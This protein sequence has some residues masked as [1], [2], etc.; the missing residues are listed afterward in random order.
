MVEF[1]VLPL[2]SST[3]KA[4]TSLDEVIIEWSEAIVIIHALVD[5]YNKLKLFANHKQTENSFRLMRI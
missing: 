4:M 1:Q 5:Y 3:L 2:E